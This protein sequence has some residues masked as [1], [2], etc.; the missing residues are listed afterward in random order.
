M[1]IVDGQVR[2]LA[3]VL[4]GAALLQF[5]L[6]GSAGAEA[7][8]PERVDSSAPLILRWEAEVIRDRLKLFPS[9]AAVD[10][11]VKD[12]TAVQTVRIRFVRGGVVHGGDARNTHGN[13]W[14]AEFTIPAAD[15]TGVY[16]VWIDARDSLGNAA[17]AQVGTLTLP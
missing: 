9:K 14:R 6:T 2:T 4:G 15:S 10:A 16:E 5:P 11:V 13:N 12:A 17:D 7:R 1:S 3:V 8:S